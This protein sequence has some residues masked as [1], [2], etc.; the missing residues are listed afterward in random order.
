MV[1]Q[2]GLYNSAL[3]EILKERK[4]ADLT[5]NREPRRLLDDAWEDGPTGDGAVKYCLEM[6]QWT[7]A[8]RT[9][10][11]DYSPSVEP[12]FGFRYA[13]DQPTD[14]VKVCGLWSDP[15]MQQPLLR[16]A[17]ERHYWYTDLPTIYVSYV[18]NHADYGGDMSLWPET[19]KELVSARLAVKIAGKLTQGT[20]LIALAEKAWKDAKLEATAGDA[21]RKPTKFLPEG[22]WNASRR[23]FGLRSSRWSGEFR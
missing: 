16:Y 17:D 7:F 5:E 19:F 13:F 22:S 23:G 11:A 3:S 1:T 21:M 12:D 2:L 20:G 4:L 6:G 15:G 10:Q 14:M 8:T 18:S 9:V